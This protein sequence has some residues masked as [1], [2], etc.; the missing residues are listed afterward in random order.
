MTS[1]S[2]SVVT[3]AL[4]RLIFG[5]IDDVN[6]SASMTFWPLPLAIWP[7]CAD[8]WIRRQAWSF[9]MTSRCRGPYTAASAAGHLEKNG[10]ISAFETF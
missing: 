8:L 10:E 9:L 2:R 7:R 3:M 6:F 4:S 1:Y 5:D